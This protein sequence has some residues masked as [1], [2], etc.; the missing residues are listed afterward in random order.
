MKNYF[1]LSALILLI[2]ISCSQTEQE[3][4]TIN[5]ED[6][7]NKPKELKLSEIAQKVEYIKLDTSE[8]GLMGWVS[9]A[10]ILKDRIVLVDNK[11]GHKG[12]FLFDKDGAFIKQIGKRGKG[13]EGEYN[14]ILGIDIDY[15]NEKIMILPG[16]Q[17]FIQ[18]YDFDG[19]FIE[20]IG[21]TEG[22]T[23]F[24]YYN[25]YIYTHSSSTWACYKQKET[26]QLLK[27]NLQGEIVNQYH[28]FTLKTEPYLA[29]FLETP[30]FSKSKGVLY[31]FVC[32]EDSLYC[33]SNDVYKACMYFNMGKYKFPEDFIWDNPQKAYRM[34]KAYIEKVK[35]AQNNTFIWYRYKGKLGLMVNNKRK[36]YNTGKEENSGIM[37][38][39]DG[40]GYMKNF[41]V[42]DSI[43]V[44]AID[45]WK[46]KEE[47]QNKQISERA[48]T[49]NKNIKHADNL[50]LRIVYLKK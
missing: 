27:R 15:E 48:Y 31:Y 41:F 36:T 39:I 16:N 46:F 17:R 7:L 8:K 30:D 12:A 2:S 5:F 37:D 47:S 29:A 28:W 35:V 4:K 26:F 21:K 32:K 50:I 13:P 19:N 38:D 42:S 18:L 23:G 45:A 22:E 43:L 34:D 40:L 25:K 14:E 6:A 33:I 49:L 11:G 1:I 44:E 9:D 20:N 10:I 24:S 3:I